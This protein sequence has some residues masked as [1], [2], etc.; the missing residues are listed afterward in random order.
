MKL[1]TLHFLF[2]FCPLCVGIAVGGSVF[3]RFLPGTKMYLIN[4]LWLGFLFFSLIKWIY[5]RWS[6]VVISEREN[7][8]RFVKVFLGFLIFFAIYLIF[9]SGIYFLN[10]REFKASYSY[11][12]HAGFFASMMAYELYHFLFEKGIKIKYGSTLVPG[13]LLTLLSVL[14]YLI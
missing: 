4:S 14:Y 2:A 13:I 6:I 10:G 1:I 9:L 8:K 7:R 11:S 3:S 5:E 12:F